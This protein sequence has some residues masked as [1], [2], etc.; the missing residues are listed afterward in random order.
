MGVW[1]SFLGA[2][3]QATDAPDSSTRFAERII[4]IPEPSK[5]D[6]GAQRI[7]SYGLECAIE[8]AGGPASGPKKTPKPGVEGVSPPDPKF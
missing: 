5:K 1:V 2:C 6:K 3:L 8:G 4:R 7:E